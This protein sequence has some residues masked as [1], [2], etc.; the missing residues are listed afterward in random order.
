[1]LCQGRWCGTATRWYLRAAAQLQQRPD[2]PQRHDLGCCLLLVRG[3]V[4]SL[5]LVADTGYEAAV[6]HLSKEV[7]SVAEKVCF[8]WA[9]LTICFVHVLHPASARLA[10]GSCR[11]HMHVHALASSLAGCISFLTTHQL[12]AHHCNALQMVGSLEG[13]EELLASAAASTAGAAGQSFMLTASLLHSLLGG[14]LDVA[15]VKDAFR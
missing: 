14:A 15:T 6:L 12:A 7:A 3:A 9:L 4:A 8:G 1:M 13:L 11:N 10:A 2:T 5:A